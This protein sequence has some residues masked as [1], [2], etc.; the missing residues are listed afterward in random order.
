MKMNSTTNEAFAKKISR[1]DLVYV[2]QVKDLKDVV[3]FGDLS[4]PEGRKSL[5][6]ILDSHYGPEPKT[7]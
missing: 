4:N 6:K 1:A 7:S 3:Y 5:L 2:P